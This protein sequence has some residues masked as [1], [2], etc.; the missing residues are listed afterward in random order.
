MTRK[1]ARLFCRLFAAN[2]VNL[3]LHAI[4]Y[5]LGNFLHTLSTP[6]P[7]KD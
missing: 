1:R 5:N 3:Q 6:E 4:A 7:I 2:T